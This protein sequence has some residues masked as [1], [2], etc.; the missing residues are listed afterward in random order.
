M[1]DYAIHLL[2]I[3]SSVRP[4]ATLLPALPNQILPLHIEPGEASF[5]YFSEFVCWFDSHYAL[6][7]LGVSFLLPRVRSTR[8]RSKSLIVV[9][10]ME[11]SLESVLLIRSSKVCAVVDLREEGRSINVLLEI[12]KR[13][14]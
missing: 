1:T 4:I 7:P 5:F 3:I 2:V 8:R 9:I 14:A 11:T 6:T 13:H 12:Y 10:V